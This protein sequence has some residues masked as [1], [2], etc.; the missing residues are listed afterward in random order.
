M[1]L[2]LSLVFSSGSGRHLDQRGV[3]VRK[4]EQDVMF[5]RAT[6]SGPPQS[7][8]VFPALFCV[9]VIFYA[10]SHLFSQQNYKGDIL[11]SHLQ[12]RNLRLRNS[13]QGFTASKWIQ[14]HSKARSSPLILLLSRQPSR[15]SLQTSIP[16]EHL[17]VYSKITTSPRVTSW[18]KDNYLM[19]TYY[20][21]E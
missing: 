17:K 20:V 16:L 8:L 12:V 5:G 7:I 10:F 13:A 2:K 6:C 9:P 18:N 11:I 19:S 21:P 4:K 3:S 14:S 15:T 1:S